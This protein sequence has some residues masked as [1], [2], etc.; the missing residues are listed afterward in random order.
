VAGITLS[1]PPYGMLP[2]TESISVLLSKM[3]IPLPTNGGWIRGDAAFA[4]RAWMCS[5]R[6]SSIGLIVASP[7]VRDHSFRKL[8]EMLVNQLQ[9]LCVTQLDTHVFHG[10]EVQAFLITGM[11]ALSRKR[12][13]LLRKASIDGTI[14]DE[15]EIGW[16]AA[17]NRLDFDYY[18]AMEKIGV[19]SALATDT[20]ASVGATIVRGSRSHN[21]FQRLGLDAFHTTDFKEFSGELTLSGQSQR[22]QLARSGDILIPRVGS[23]CLLNQ[24]KVVKGAGLFTDCVYRLSVKKNASERVWRTLASSFGAEWR[25]A[26]ASGNCA[27]HLTVQTLLGMPLVS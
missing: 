12:N 11:R 17:V 3:D 20:L 4:V 6:G 10:A 9:G 22:Y 8:R 2:L 7:L 26:N 23:R 24:A 13:V 25:L 18:K 21:D 1:N 19:S 5:A 27:K 14:V 16:S 15:L